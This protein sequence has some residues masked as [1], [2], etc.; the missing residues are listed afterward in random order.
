[1]A[2]KKILYDVVDQ[3][4]AMRKILSNLD[5]YRA[6]INLLWNACP[7]N[8]R[9]PAPGFKKSGVRGQSIRREHWRATCKRGEQHATSPVEYCVGIAPVGLRIKPLQAGREFELQTAA[10]LWREIL[11]N[12]VGIF[13]K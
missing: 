7:I 10:D 8:Y 4:I 12:G 5:P 13:S 3:H 1:H 2:L 6:A 11:R 9:V